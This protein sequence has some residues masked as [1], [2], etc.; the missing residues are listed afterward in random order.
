MELEGFESAWQKRPLEGHSLPAPDPI[1]QPLQFLR[2][3]AICE[4]ERY[5]KDL[6]VQ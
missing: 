4:L 1:S 6:S 2:T 5:L 3:S